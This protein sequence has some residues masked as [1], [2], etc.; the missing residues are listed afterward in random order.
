[1]HNRNFN[2]M[3]HGPMRGPGMGHGPMRGPGMGMGPGFGRG[4]MHRGPR[5][6][7]PMF[8]GPVFRSRP[9]YYYGYG[10][11]TF[12][13]LGPFLILILLASIFGIR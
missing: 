4:P 3:G 11:G 5:P 10:P 8:F 9:R 12:G 7:R 13:C 6:M 2:H 1:M